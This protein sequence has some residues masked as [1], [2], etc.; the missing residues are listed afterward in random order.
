MILLFQVPRE[1]KQAYHFVREDCYSHGNW[2]YQRI[3]E[4]DLPVDVAF[5]G[6]SVS[7]HA[8][9]DS[10][11]QEVIQ[12]SLNLERP[13]TLSNFGY[14]R[15][16]L[17]LS[18]V[19][20]KDILKRKKVKL[21]VLEVPFKSTADSHP[22]FGNLAEANTVINPPEWNSSYF[23]NVLKASQTRLSWFREGFWKTSPNYYKPYF[24]AYGFGTGFLERDEETLEKIR[25]KRLEKGPQTGKYHKTVQTQVQAIDELCQSENVK[26]VLW[27]GKTFGTAEFPPD[28]LDFYQSNWNYFEPP[29]KPFETVEFLMDEDH[30]NTEGAE[31]LIPFFR[32]L[33]ISS[34]DD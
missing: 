3:F 8:V 25:K 33:V 14:C 21:V 2:I 20:L 4:Q 29:S 6:T 27:Y 13:I 34:L 18:Y 24:T 22:I 5:L 7:I 19:I 31:E 16:G 26:L 15:P 10:L 28:N 9:Y 32:D 1:P 23:S 17:D 12:D 30:L 11:I